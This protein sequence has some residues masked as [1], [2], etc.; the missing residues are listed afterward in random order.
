[1][2]KFKKAP[3]PPYYAVVFTSLRTGEDDAGYD[4]M[5]EKMERMAAQQPGY[6]G[7]ESARGEDGLGITVSYWKDQASLKAWK[8][9]SEHLAAQ[10]LGRTR[11]YRWYHVR[12]AKVERDYSF[13][14]DR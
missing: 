6:L 14:K 9:V 4:K 12:V 5:A 11:W 8:K 7:I 10:A 3:Q 13:R 1:M 2:T